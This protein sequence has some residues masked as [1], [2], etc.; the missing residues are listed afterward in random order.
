MADA[1]S[2]TIRPWVRRGNMLVNADAL[3]HDDPDHTFNQIV[4]Q[5]R[6]PEDFG[7]SHPLDREFDGKSRGEL[8]AEILRLRVEITAW[9]RG[10]L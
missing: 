2:V 5:G 6:K 1:K 7:V 9:A 3:E 10:L 8:I 4:A